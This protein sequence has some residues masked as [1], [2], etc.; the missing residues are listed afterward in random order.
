MDATAY[1]QLAEL[2]ERHFWFVGRRAI[3][4]TVLDRLLAGRRDLTVVEIGCGAGNLLRRLDRYGRVIGLEIAPDIAALALER[5]HKPVLCGDG[6]ALPLPGACADLVC[7]FDTLEHIA[8]EAATLREIRRILTPGGLAVFTV[9]AYQF[10]WS[11]NDRVAHHHRRYTRT[12]LKRTLAD[13]GFE[14]VRFSYYNTFLFPLILPA[15]LLLKAKERLIG[16]KDPDH[17][18]LSVR[19][20]APLNSVLAAIMSSER[21]F[22]GRLSFPFG[23]SLLGI[24]RKPA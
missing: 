4:F 14:A 7:L 1:R 9:P 23:H 6:A 11:N 5:S 15:V 8:D 17:T 10:L 18:N 3:F 12:R 19:I 21:R 16:L 13:A 22:L 20:P 2:E 24:V